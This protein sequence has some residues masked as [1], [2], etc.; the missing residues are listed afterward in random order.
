MDRKKRKKKQ[1]N[2]Q[3]NKLVLENRRIS[4]NID[5]IKQINSSRY[6]DEQRSQ[7]K[8]KDRLLERKFVV[9]R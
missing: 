8:W 6:K 5:T 1:T 2:K 7:T 4:A 3:T 9:E